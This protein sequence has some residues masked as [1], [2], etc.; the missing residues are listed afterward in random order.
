MLWDSR[1]KEAAPKHQV[2][3][4]PLADWQLFAHLAIGPQERSLAMDARDTLRGYHGIAPYNQKNL[5]Q[6]LT[7][8]GDCATMA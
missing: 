5:V 3:N 8:S 1:I 6:L 7:E 4:Q 2:A